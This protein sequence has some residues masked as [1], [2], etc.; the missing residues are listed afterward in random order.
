MTLQQIALRG[1]VAAICS[2]NFVYVQSVQAYTLY[3]DRSDWLNALNGLT[4][5]TDN[6]SSPKPSAQIFAFDSGVISTGGGG[7]IDNK[8]L[9]GIYTGIVDGQKDNPFAYDTITWSFPQAITAFG[10]DW[11]STSNQDRLTVTGNFDGTGDQTINFFDELGVFSGFKFLGI[12][13]G[14]SF[15]T[16]TFGT[17]GVAGMSGIELFAAEDLSF[18]PDP[19]RTPAT[20]IPAPTLLPGLIGMGILLIRKKK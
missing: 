16:I 20:S 9:N 15:T 14:D 7:G 12:I 2:L 11:F 4:I 8:V 5:T 19:I 3:T 17:Q 6:F 1:F 10:A 13:G 18:A